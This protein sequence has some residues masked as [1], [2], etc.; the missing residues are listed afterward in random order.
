MA[1]ETKS[2]SREEIVEHYAIEALKA[3]HHDELVYLKRALLG[4]YRHGWEAAVAQ[5]KAHGESAS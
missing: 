1:P 5:Q 2:F 3:V 4:A